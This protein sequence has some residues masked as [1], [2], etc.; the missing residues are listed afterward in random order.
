MNLNPRRHEEPEI[1][2]VPLIDV[3][4]VLLIFF[5]VTTTFMRDA[6]LRV[7]LPQAGRSAPLADAQTLEVEI[8][9]SGHYFINGRQL[10]DASARTLEQGIEQIAGSDRRRPLVIRADGKAS[11]QSVVTV[12]DVA[13][14]LGFSQLSIATASETGGGTAP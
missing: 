11:H 3:V 12:M 1:N 7:S 10:R 14:A 5:M 6:G 8:D 2:L 13:G 4:L 9:A